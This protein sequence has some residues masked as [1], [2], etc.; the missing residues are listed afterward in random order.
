MTDPVNSPAHYRDGRAFEVIDVLE[1]W[2]ARAPGPLEGS[3][4]FSCLKYLGRMWDKG[5]PIQ[6]ARKGLWFLTRLIERLEA[7]E[8]P[9]DPGPD[10]YKAHLAS[11]AWP[12]YQEG[13]PVFTFTDQPY[14]GPAPDG[15]GQT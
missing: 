11:E 9:F 15:E 13:G 3:L 4:Q 10:F 2:V 12:S 14:A 7:Q 1:D 6:D 5:N 8:L